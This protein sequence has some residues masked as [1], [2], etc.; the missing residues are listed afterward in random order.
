MKL[1]ENVRDYL[2]GKV[3]T[4]HSIEDDIRNTNNIDYSVL[5]FAVQQ[6]L[7]CSATTIIPY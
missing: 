5:A 1:Y 6:G 4:D 7:R 2:S 3:L